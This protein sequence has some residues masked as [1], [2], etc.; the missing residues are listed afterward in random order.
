PRQPATT[1]QPSRPGTRALAGAPGL[2]A[3]PLPARRP[4]VCAA[5]TCPALF[6][7]LADPAVA[8]LPAGVVGQR[9]LEFDRIEIGPVGGGEIEFRVGELPEQEV[10]DALLATGAHAEIRCRQVGQRKLPGKHVFVDLLR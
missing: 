5:S 7:L 8:A 6:Q 4:S 1:V 3:A 10:A 9:A 2:A